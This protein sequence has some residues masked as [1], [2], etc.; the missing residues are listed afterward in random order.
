[1]RLR[2]RSSVSIPPHRAPRRR[3]RVLLLARGSA[4][5][6]RQDHMAEKLT[7]Y[8]F[9]RKCLPPSQLQLILP[10]KLDEP[11]PKTTTLYQ[12]LPI[13]ILLKQTF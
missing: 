10:G 12:Q 7:D 9:K 2:P 3:R 8:A 13:T 1:M 4:K 5:A 6:G 11:T